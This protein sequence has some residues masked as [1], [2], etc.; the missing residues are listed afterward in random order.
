MLSKI[1]ID[2]LS[3]FCIECNINF[4]SDEI[5]LISWK[6][7]VKTHKPTKLPPDY[8]A[9]YI[10]EYNKK[11]LKVGKVSGS[12][13][14]DRYYQHHYIPKAANSTLAKSLINDD[15]FSKTCNENNVRDWILKNTNRY[16]ILIPQKY[17]RN[18]VNFVEAYFI[19]KLN[20]IFE[21]RK[22]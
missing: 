1:D 15:L 18:F 12:N 8:F 10:F 7:G 14:N 6:K 11:I 19:L 5:E 9:V 13:N 3:N 16:N 22:N 2:I 20:P 4:N 21:G 17:G